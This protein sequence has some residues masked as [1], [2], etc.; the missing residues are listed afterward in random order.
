MFK[1]I[2]SAVDLEHPDLALRT[3]QTA[4]FVGGEG[5]D[6]IV[7]TVIPPIGGGIV[8]SFL[9][10][11]FDQRIKQEAEER[12]RAFVQQHFP[13]DN[14]RIRCLVAHGPV[15]EEINL[16]SEQHQADL[17]VVAAARPDNTGLGPN[18]ARVAR[19]GKHS[20]LIIR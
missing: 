5:A 17:V 1:R 3:V 2:L 7:I 15:Y 13:Q 20:V 9:P 11:N 14:D 4:L 6:Y 18:A 12:L 19:Y 8:T 10:K 16:A